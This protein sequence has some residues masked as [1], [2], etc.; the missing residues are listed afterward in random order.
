MAIPLPIL[1]DNVTM[2][3]SLSLYPVTFD[4]AFVA[5]EN[6]EKVVRAGT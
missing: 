4:L 5:R 3:V 6:V 1:A 2:S